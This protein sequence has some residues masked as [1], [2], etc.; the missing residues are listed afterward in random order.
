MVNK[1]YHTISEDIA[2]PIEGRASRG[3]CGQYG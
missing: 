3:G 2:R 1:S